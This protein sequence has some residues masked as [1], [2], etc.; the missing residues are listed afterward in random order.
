MRNVWLPNT[1]SALEPW[2][3]LPRAGIL[4]GAMLRLL[5]ALLPTLLSAMRSRGL[6]AD[7]VAPPGAG[8]KYSL[9]VTQ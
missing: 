9:C 1:P 3:I 2:T 5:V 4:A 8:Y 6:C 7:N